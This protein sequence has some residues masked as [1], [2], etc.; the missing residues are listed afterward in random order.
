MKSYAAFFVALLLA[1]P[2]ALKSAQQLAPVETFYIDFPELGKTWKGEPVRAG[3]YLPS[4][5][6]ADKKLPMF[7][8]FGGEAG[9]DNPKRA[10]EII[11]GEGFICVALPYLNEVDGKKGGTYH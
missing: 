10:V 8:W 7:V 6:S 2:G 1:F 9:S 3:V 11:E 5:Y 4:D